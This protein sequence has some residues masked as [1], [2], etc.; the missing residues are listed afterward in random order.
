MVAIIS[1]IVSHGRSISQADLPASR[2]L[3]Q[4]WKEVKAVW[5]FAPNSWS[6]L[7]SHVGRAKQADLAD[8]CVRRRSKEARNCKHTDLPPAHHQDATLATS[9]PSSIPHLLNRGEGCGVAK[10]TVDV[11]AVHHDL[12]SSRER[13]GGRGAWVERHLKEGFTTP[14]HDADV[15][16]DPN[17]KCKF[18]L[19]SCHHGRWSAW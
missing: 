8:H 17:R 1:T 2:G 10:K 16:G 5:L 6:F 13:G 9:L 12:L 4:L 19:S 7:E 3:D 11:S 18:T 15:W 14:S